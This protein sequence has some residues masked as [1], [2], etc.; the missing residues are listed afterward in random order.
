MSELTHKNEIAREFRI[1]PKP[2]IYFSWR[3]LPGKI[4][5][6]KPDPNCIRADVGVW[7]VDNPGFGRGQ[8]F[9]RKSTD[10]SSR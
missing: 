4:Q 2:E 8:F 1:R 10:Y 6:S 7:L 3:K 9:R 5:F